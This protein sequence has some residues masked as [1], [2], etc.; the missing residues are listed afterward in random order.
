MSERLLNSEICRKTTVT[1]HHLVVRP[2]IVAR[3]NH[4][5][6]RPLTSRS[7]K[8][9]PPRRRGANLPYGARRDQWM[10]ARD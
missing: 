5:R 2:T 6:Q 1:R 8:A 10:S 4:R 9:T 7:K 3:Y